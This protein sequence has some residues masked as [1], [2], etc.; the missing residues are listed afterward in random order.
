MKLKDKLAKVSEDF[1]VTKYDNGYLVKVRGE[2]HNDA[3]DDANILCKDLLE[4]GDFMNEWDAM[5][6]A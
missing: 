6:K 4:V 1:D 2:N 5:E 3:W